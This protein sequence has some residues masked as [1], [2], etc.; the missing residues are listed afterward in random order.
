M[1]IDRR[2]L[3]ADDDA[4]VRGGAAE[5]LSAMGLVIVEADCGP[6]AIE[7]LRA[8]PIHLALLDYHMPGSDGLEVFALMR[9]ET[10][11]IP[12][13]F[14]SGDAP[15]PVREVAMRQ[16]AS[17]FL[18]KPVRPDLLRNEVRRIL[19]THWGWVA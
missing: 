5:L 4:E 8:G 13:M 19:E 18:Q 17:A 6:A 16:G 7:I 2:I 11:E 15:E 1:S 9:E 3:I 14:W 10:L 12:C